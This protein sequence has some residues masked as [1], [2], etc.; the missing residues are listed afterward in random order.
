MRNLKKLLAVIVSVCV[1]ATFALPA[2]AAET[3]LTDAE[4][5]E[6]LGVVKGEGAGLTDDYLAKGTTRLQAAIM[7]LRM[8]K[9]E[10]AAKAY[11]GEENFDDAADVAWAEG[12]AILGYLKANPDLGWAGVGGNKFD[13]YGPAS[14]QMMYKVAL[15]ALGYKQDAEDGFKWAD[16]FT[17]AAD[18]GLG[19]VAD[20]TELTNDDMCTVVVEMLGIKVKDGDMTL[21]EKL[22]ADGVIDEADAIEVGLIAATPEELEIESVT[23]T[24]LIQAVVTYNQKVD[25]DTAA[26]KD[27]YKFATADKITVKEAA[28]AEDGVSVVLTFVASVGQQKDAK[29]TVNNVKSAEG[30]AI[31]KT[32]KEVSFLDSSIPEVVSAEVAGI[33]TIKVTFSEPM[34]PATVTAS[35]FKVNDGKYYV[36][37]ATGQNNNTE[38]RVEL[39]TSLKD[40]DLPFE[41]KAGIAEDWA[42][43]TTLGYKT[44]L[45]VNEDKDAPEVVSYEN[46]KPYS[47]TLIWNEDISFISKDLTK[48]YHTNSSN[49][50]SEAPVIDGNKMTLTFNKDHKLP[51]GTAYVY[52]MKEVIKDLWNNKNAQQMVMLDVVVDKD[53]PVLQSVEAEKQNKLVLTFDEPVEK[54]NKTANYTILDKDGKEVKNILY[55]VPTVDSTGKKVTVNLSKDLGGDYTL[56]VKDIED[57]YENA[58]AST[59][60]AF[61][62]EDKKAPDVTKINARLYAPDGT[63]DTVLKILFP[64]AMAI[65]GAYGV[66]DLAK[67]F[68][69]NNGTPGD[70]KAVKD[71]DDVELAVV[72]DAKAVEITFTA[73]ALAKAN[74]VLATGTDVLRIA[75]IADAAGN[76]T[77]NLQ[78]EYDITGSGTVSIKEVELT[79]AKEVKVYFTDE[80]AYLNEDEIVIKKGTEK[81]PLTETATLSLKDG[82]SVATFKLQNEFK[83]DKSDLSVEVAVPAGASAITTMN[84]YGGLLTTGAVAGAN[85]KDKLAP[86]IDKVVFVNK[87]LIKVYFKED[88]E[89]DLFAI[90]GKN[91]FDVLG[92]D[93]ALAELVTP[94]TDG[95]VVLLKSTKDGGNFTTATGVSYNGANGIADLSNNGLKEVTKASDDIKLGALTIVAATPTANNTFTVKNDFDGRAHDVGDIDMDPS[96]DVVDATV[97]INGITYTATAPANVGTITAT[98]ASTDASAATTATFTVTIDGVVKTVVM[99]IPAYTGVDTPTVQQPTIAGQ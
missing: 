82:A 74:V 36:K 59:S 86:E 97:E 13:P 33:S 78:D 41:M 73:P 83:F 17:F 29:L 84:R 35:A 42:K 38:F 46:A 95:N 76:Y 58:M 94:G 15:E 40:G 22:V 31:A 79:G 52:V 62:A 43:F 10:D 57:K 64:E 56:V 20:V 99:S 98:G 93:L 21:V 23:A 4:I 69:L 1:L 51:N 96:T 28:L 55:G 11:T 67:Y 92:G 49:P 63:T 85:I 53:P 91:G 50:V 75:R 61:T 68:I 71:I 77:A 32:T 70:W 25:K 16:V 5:C 87:A 18:K 2:F 60:M 48:Y 8:L 24:N 44:T 90:V 30:V 89:A 19:K 47:V 3:A 80:L 54:Y 37:G 14:A 81:N 12:K 27:N 7:Y 6:D 39:Y 65:E 34:N 9:L 72:D 66:D 26:D 88:L 45:K